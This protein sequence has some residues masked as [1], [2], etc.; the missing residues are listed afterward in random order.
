ME[1]RNAIDLSTLKYRR[2]GLGCYLMGRKDTLGALGTGASSFVN[3]QQTITPLHNL[4]LGP[5]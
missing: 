3:A 1:Q 2:T 4:P 5:L